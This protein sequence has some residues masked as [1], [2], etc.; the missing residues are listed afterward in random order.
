MEDEMNW[1]MMNQ[2]FM[3]ISAMEMKE[4]QG[5]FHEKCKQIIGIH[6]LHQVSTKPGR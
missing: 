2:V 3:Y 1:K 4:Y 6:K 5:E